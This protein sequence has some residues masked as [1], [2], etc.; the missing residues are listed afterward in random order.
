MAISNPDETNTRIS[1]AEAY[2]HSH[3]ILEMF[4]DLSTLICYTRPTNIKE[5][6]I[7]EL[8]SRKEKGPAGHVIFTD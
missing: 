5:F 2:L 8:K 1:E 4:E 7:Q 3:S 6:L